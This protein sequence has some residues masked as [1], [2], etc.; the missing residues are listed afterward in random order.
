MT[1]QPHPEFESAFVEALINQRGKG[2]VPQQTLHA[3]AN[4]LDQPIDNAAYA[5]RMAAFLKK[6]ASD[7]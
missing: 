2:V 7:G 3:A 5:A 4:R 6:G 1:I